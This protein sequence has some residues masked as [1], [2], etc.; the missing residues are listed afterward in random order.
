MKKSKKIFLS[1]LAIFM[2]ASMTGCKTKKQEEH[3]NIF[4]ISLMD[5]SST[6]YSWKYELSEEG[7][8]DVTY[9]SDY[10]KCP[11]ENEGCTGRRVYT[12]KA[13]KPGKV[14]LSLTY[15]FVEPDKYKKKTAIYEITVNDDLTIS[16]THYGTYFENK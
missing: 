11:K 10:S 4:E 9:G 6:G 16:E 2:I 1:I 8:I 3:N 5:N 15:S 7:I 14:K 13:L 12:I